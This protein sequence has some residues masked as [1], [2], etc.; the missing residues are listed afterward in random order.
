MPLTRTRSAGKTP[1]VFDT[2]AGRLRQGQIV[3]LTSLG[4]L[5]WLM[6]ALFIRYGVPADLFGGTASAML[7]A[8]SVP[9]ALLLVLTSKRVAGLRP[10]QLVAGVAFAAAVAMLCD[11][12]TL[13]WFPALYGGASENLVPAAAWLLWGVGVCLI[14]AFVDGARKS[15]N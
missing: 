11:G 1:S 6:A 13:T 2:P 14:L 8:L 10:D 4:F 3:I 5:F 7:F 9:C 12:V 15:G